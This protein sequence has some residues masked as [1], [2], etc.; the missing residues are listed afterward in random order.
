MSNRCISC[1]AGYG[2]DHLLWCAT[3]QPDPPVVYDLEEF[4]RQLKG[5]RDDLR[6]VG[7]RE[8]LVAIRCVL[9]ALKAS[10]KP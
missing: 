1:G 9:D 7:E 6:S 5:K 2:D 3:L 4:E 10:R 8:A